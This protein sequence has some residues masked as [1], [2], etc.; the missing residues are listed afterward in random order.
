[1]H[2]EELAAHFGAATELPIEP[3]DIRIK[4]LAAGIVGQINFYPDSGLPSGIIRGFMDLYEAEFLTP[5]L[6]ADIYF[7]ADMESDWSR[8]VWTKEMMNIFDSNDGGEAVVASDEKKVAQLVTEMVTP[9]DMYSLTTVFDRVAL[10]W[11]IFLLFPKRIRDRLA[12]VYAAGKIR[13]LS[14]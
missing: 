1:M 8:L 14:R 11:A 13:E 6:A 12:P 10:V 5:P 4:I 9:P 7:A 2:R 3:D